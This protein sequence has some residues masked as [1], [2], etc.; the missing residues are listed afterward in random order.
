MKL[1]MNLRMSKTDVGIIH[2]DCKCNSEMYHGHQGARP[3]N[4][5]NTDASDDC[6]EKDHFLFQCTAAGNY[7]RVE[8]N[9]MKL[10]YY[11]EGFITTLPDDITKISLELKNG[12]VIN[13][14]ENSTGV[15][16]DWGEKE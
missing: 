10:E 5:C 13:I 4:S 8:A 6:R 15:N 16:V 1:S 7:R 3:K 12:Q 14:I 9:T 11:S 2:N